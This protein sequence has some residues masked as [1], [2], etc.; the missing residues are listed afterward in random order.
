MW[1]GAWIA[2]NA[3]PGDRYLGA[4]GQLPYVVRLGKDRRAARQALQHEPS[5]SPH[6]PQRVGQQHP[7]V[8]MH[9]AGRVVR[10]AQRRDGRH[11]IKVPVGEHHGYGLEAVLHDQLGDTVPLRPSP[12]R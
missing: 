10:A 6:G 7:V 9:P 5:L 2:W 3:S 8:G 1:P 11:V 4:V 12:D